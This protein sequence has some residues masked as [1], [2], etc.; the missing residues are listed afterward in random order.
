[1]VPLS[2]CA[3]LLHMHNDL[4]IIM[5]HLGGWD[6]I[7]SFYIQS[8]YT[9]AMGWAVF[10]TPRL[11]SFVLQPEPNVCRKPKLIHAVNPKL[12]FLP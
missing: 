5:R 8:I 10:E 12:L 2:L 11:D 3:V 7:S 1:M 4:L 6:H 9:E